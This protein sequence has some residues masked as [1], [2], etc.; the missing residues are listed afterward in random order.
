MT[1]LQTLEDLG[2]DVIRSPYRH[3]LAHGV[4]EADPLDMTRPIHQN[5]L[6]LDVSMHEA[7]LVEV[8]DTESDLG[9]VD[10]DTI[11]VDVVVH[12]LQ[13]LR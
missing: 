4:P 3:H 10:P 7:H 1:A 6:R 2:G 13:E 12:P 9:C 8:V 11:L 5:V